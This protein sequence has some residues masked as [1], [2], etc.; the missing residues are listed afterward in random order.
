MHDAG[1]VGM[2]TVQYIGVYLN[3]CMLLSVHRNVVLG[4]FTSQG[5]YQMSYLI[6]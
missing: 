1:I 5:G 3:F 4:Q 2:N 6:V